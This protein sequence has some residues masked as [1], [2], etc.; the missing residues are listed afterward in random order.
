MEGIQCADIAFV[1]RQDYLA[2]RAEIEGDIAQSLIEQYSQGM[3]ANRNR[4]V[5]LGKGY[6]LYSTMCRKMMTITQDTVG[7]HDVIVA[8]CNPELNYS[9]WGDIAIGKR[10]CKENITDALA[11]YGII[12]H[13][14]FTFNIFMDYEIGQ[15]GVIIYKETLSKPGDY[16]DF[17]AEMDVIVAISNCP[18]ELS[19]VNGFEPTQLRVAVFEQ[20]QYLKIEPDAQM[21]AILV[22]S[23]RSSGRARLRTACAR[24]R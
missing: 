18:Q 2:K 8:W 21:E 16:I 10:T 3:T 20:E 23:S 17:K 6:P 19:L 1:C 13:L 7:N 5:Y 9:R 14:P 24:R 11:E 4:H 12:V 15:D 22:D